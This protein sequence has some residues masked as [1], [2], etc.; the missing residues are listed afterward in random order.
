MNVLFSSIASGIIAFAYTIPFATSFK[1]KSFK[2]CYIICGIEFVLLTFLQIRYFLPYFYNQEEYDPGFM[3]YFIDYLGTAAIMLVF[4]FITFFLI[5]ECSIECPHCHALNSCTFEKVLNRESR[6]Q[7]ETV[8]RDIKDNNGNTIGSYETRELKT[9]RH[10]TSE[11][12]CK[13]C[14]K[15]FSHRYAIK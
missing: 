3:T 7:W 2:A 10:E 1:P 13:R 9:Y 5:L 15:N 14:G 11:F 6:E 12:K 4:S 8:D